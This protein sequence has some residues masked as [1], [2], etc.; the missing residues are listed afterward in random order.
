MHLTRHAYERG[1]QRLGLPKRALDRLAPKALQH[2]TSAR[3]YVGRMRR[4]L[5]SVYHYNERANN[6]RVY[7]EHV[8]VFDNDTLITVFPVPNDLRK[9]VK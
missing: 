7:G 2:G 3:D 8:F 1:K 4:Y 6:V 5:D 9:A